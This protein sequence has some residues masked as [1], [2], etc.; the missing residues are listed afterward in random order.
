MLETDKIYNKTEHHTRFLEPKDDREFV[1]I[2][3]KVFEVVYLGAG[4]ANPGYG[5]SVGVYGFIADKTRD[6]LKITITP[7]DSTPPEELA[8]DKTFIDYPIKGSGRILYQPKEGHIEVRAFNESSKIRATHH[9][10]DRFC[11]RADFEGL[12][13]LRIYKPPY[14]DTEQATGLVDFPNVDNLG[15]RRFRSKYMEFTAGHLGEDFNVRVPRSSAAPLTRL[16][17]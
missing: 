15:I 2:E 13:L 10:G 3:G 5:Y 11:Y 16:V 9:Q 7:E 14:S 17:Y 12:E 4:K 6:L 8:L 1:E